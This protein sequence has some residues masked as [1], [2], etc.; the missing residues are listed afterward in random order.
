MLVSAARVWCGPDRPAIEGG[1]VLTAAGR[2]VAVGPLVEVV[3]AAPAGVRRIDCPDSTVL[4]G[5]ID[6]HVHL[7]FD[8]SDDPVAVLAGLG[9]ADLRVGM[10]VRARRLVDS[11]VTTARD[12]GDRSGLAIALR[13]DIA[14]GRVRGPR[15]LAAG[16]PLTTPGGHCWFLGGEVTGADLAEAGRRAVATGADVVK[17]MATGGHLTG[18]GPPPWVSQYTAA[19]LTTLVAAVHAGARPVAAHAHG[20]EGIEAAIAA[21]VDSIEHCAWITA[22]GPDLRPELVDRIV[23][24]GITV[25][26]TASSAWNDEYFGAETVEWATGYVG[27]MHRAG[28]RLVAGT[29]AGVMGVPFDA[30][31]EGLR[32]FGAAGLDPI[33]ILAAATSGAAASLGLGDQIGRLAPGYAA[34]LV[35]AD[36][37]PLTDVNTLVS[38]LAKPRLVVAAGHVVAQTKA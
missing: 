2:I 36:G 16:P 10:A 18:S 23:E 11:G 6:T 28:V 3:E 15:L 34:D 4:P 27:R 13:A 24:R 8:A 37:D 38:G 25:C 9:D 17:V 33:E 5:L 1:A 26:P 31:A 30:Y 29:D 22:D 19:E 14:A 7:A 12:L 35:V 32:V 21:G 20:V